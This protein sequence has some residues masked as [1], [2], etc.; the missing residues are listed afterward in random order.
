[1]RLSDWCSDVCSS[2]FRYREL[3]CYRYETRRL[4]AS[5][6]EHYDA[7][8]LPSSSGP[9]PI[10]LE[11]TGSRTLPVYGSFLGI[12][13]YSLPV[14]ESGSL[15]FGLQLAGFADADY[16]LTRHAQWVMDALKPK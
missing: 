11:S 3:L 12:P 16:H 10:G 1:M 9:A 6:G 7:F 2:G 14:M 15:P 13:A 8:V 5:L 4:W